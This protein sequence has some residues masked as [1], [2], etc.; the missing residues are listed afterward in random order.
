MERGRHGS[1]SRRRTGSK[2][3]ASRGKAAPAAAVRRPSKS[4]LPEVRCAVST[5]SSSHPRAHTHMHPA[6]ASPASRLCPSRRASKHSTPPGFVS[7][8][9]HFNQLE[10]CISQAVLEGLR[11]V[12]EKS[13]TGELNL[14]QFKS[15][16]FRLVDAVS[17]PEA[18]SMF[19]TQPRLTHN[20]RSRSAA[21]LSLSSPFT[22][23]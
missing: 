15:E 20:F 11:T 6:A 13:P 4:T 23:L 16:C 10:T 18:T 5:C 9:H 7:S 14:E 8:P 22:G 1:S 3:A 17:L 12:F 2:G 21:S 19:S